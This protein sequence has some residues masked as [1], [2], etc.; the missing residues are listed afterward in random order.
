MKN[1]LRGKLPFTVCAVLVLV[2]AT[3]FVA[4]LTD[5]QL[6][7]GAEY[8][9]MAN[10]STGYNVETP[11][12]RGEILD[13]NGVGLVTNNTHYKIVIDK[14][15]ADDS[16]LDSFLLSLME[17]LKTTGDKWDD[18]LP[19][20]LQDG[21]FVYQE[22]KDEEIQTLLETIEAT[23]EVTAQRCIDLMCKRY[24][25][26][27][28]LSDKEKRALCSVRYNMEISGYSNAVPYTFA[29]DVSRSGVSAVS[30]NT[31]GVSGVDV[32]T[33]LVRA[34]K[35]PT[36]APHV[37]GAL[38]AV[39]EEEFK[40]L[41]HSPK[42]YTINDTVGKS[43][44][45][46]AME[47]ELKGEGG[48]KIIQRN[49]DGTIVETV[50][51]KESKPG[52]TVYLTLDEKVQQATAESLERN[53]KAAQEA[54]R[55]AARSSGKALQGEDCQAGAAVMLDVSS[56]AVLAAASYPTYDLNRYSSD[57]AYYAKLAN[58]KTSPM[59]NRAL[60]GTFAWG[61]VF[62][63]VVALAALEEKI[64]KPTD[65]VN[66]TQKYD[67][68]PSNVVQCMHRHDTVDL[69]NA[70]TQSCNY[71]FAETGRKL[72]IDT[73]Y[74]Y[75]ERFGLGEYTGIEIEE[76][77]GTLAGRDS[78]GWMPGNTVQAA[79]GQADN[80]FTPLQ[81]ATYVA[82]IANNGVRLKTHIISKITDYE[83]KNVL[84]SYDEPVKTEESGVS[85][86]NLKTVQEDMLGVT[87]DAVGTAN[88]MFGDYKIKVAAKTGTAENPGSDN[89]AF[90]CYAPYDKPKVAVAVM[91]E[92]GVRNNYSLQIA[93]DML[94]SYFFR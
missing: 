48:S 49:S 16:T 34:A 17:L 58:D 8:K 78:R 7:H 40:E 44:V 94:D 22:K 29:S 25:I 77:R 63:P 70:I 50:E 72:G 84:A 20:L 47:E 5:W 15:Y 45:E 56:F 41:S 73:M 66:C 14:V 91:V 24:K 68:Y 71:Y 90:I 4:R 80:A 75:A 13:R 83:R 51:T 89:T 64:I 87:Q 53:I 92:H 86:A 59:Y 65:T 1:K 52:N 46:A 18:T 93:K 43:G 85:A 11:A 74:L 19:V 69:R 79:I 39:T 2:A 61:S 21:V 62:K 38:G 3:V 55:Q 30:E 32:Q 81:L 36:L 12:T 54:G 27:G 88:Y 31:Q 76:S 26:D 9:R 6:I 42:H 10:R 28:G 33:Y 82:T 67:Y 37:L 23:G 35:N 60:S 57:D